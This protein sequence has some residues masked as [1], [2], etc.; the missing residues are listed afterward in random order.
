MSYSVDL[1]SSDDPS[2]QVRLGR[3]VGAKQLGVGHVATQNS[4]R[5]PLLQNSF[6]FEPEPELGSV[7]LLLEAVGQGLVR[8]DRT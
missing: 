1:L 3:V 6:E 5:F 8:E 2:L 4:V 7:P